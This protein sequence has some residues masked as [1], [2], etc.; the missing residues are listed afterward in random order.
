MLYLGKRSG[1]IWKERVIMQTAKD[2]TASSN[3]RRAR[4]TGPA[5]AAEFSIASNPLE[6]YSSPT[7]QDIPA[8]NRN[9]QPRGD[10][11]GFH[12]NMPL[13]LD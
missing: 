6:L 12:S 1:V 5:L 9:S 2:S 7:I 4:S 3:V 11:N 10:G 13:C 8:L